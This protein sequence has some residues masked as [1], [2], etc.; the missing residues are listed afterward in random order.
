[1][2]KFGVS[3]FWALVFGTLLGGASYFRLERTDLIGEP[4]WHATVRLWLE[5]LEWAT[6]DWRARELGAASTPS[7][8]VVI[9]TVDE[10]TQAD[11]RE[12]EKP[13]WAMRPWPRDLSGAVIEQALKE[14]A[15]TVVFDQA[16]DDV[17]PHHCA[18]CRAEPK[19]SDDELFGDR[20]DKHAG[21]VVLTWD[22]SSNRPTQGNRPLMPVLVKLG[23]FDDVR[24]ALPMVREVLKHR[25]VTY[26]IADGGRQ[27]VWAGVASEAKARDLVQSVDPRVPVTTRPLL[28]G[29]DLH[30][31]SPSWLAVQLATVSVPGL[32]ADRLWRAR[33]VE[34]PVASLETPYSGAATLVPDADGRIRSVPL[35]VAADGADGRPVI[36]ASAVIRAVLQRLDDKSL[37]YEKGRLEIGKRISLPMDA[38]GT[39]QLRFDVE[40]VSR[41]G[42]STVKRSLPAF[43]LLVNRE[44]DEVARGIRHH[45]NELTGR[46]IVFSDERLAS[47]VVPTPVGDLH[48]SAVLAQ[49]IVNVLHAQSVVRVAPETDLWMTLAFAFMGAVLSVAWSSL[50][51]RPG[52]LAWVATLAGVALLHGL[53]ARQLFVQ[54]LRW[55]AMAAP[56]L[57]CAMTFLA[58]L[59]YARTIEQGLRDFVLR[60]LGGAVRDDVFSRVE[61]DLALMRPE[62]RELT[63]YFSDIEGF[64]VVAHEKDPGEVVQVLRAYLEEM[65]TVV[66]DSQG[67]VDKYLGDGL[68]AFWGAPVSLDNQVASACAAALEMQKRFEAKRE[69]WEKALG[70]T[71]ML[72]AGFDTGPTVVGEMG[73]LHRVNYTVMGE[74]VAASYRLEALAKKYNARVLV[75]PRVPELAGSKYFFREV[76]SI[77]LNRASEVVRIYELLGTEGDPAELMEWSLAM[78]AYR[79]RRFIEAR[80]IFQ[81]L[82]HSVPLATRY[83]R[84]CEALLQSPPPDPWDGTF[85]D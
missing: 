67:H 84:R 7:D 63:V 31:V 66:L 12:R 10:E 32:D 27:G 85:N 64:T 46:V 3:F 78:T 24:A 75:G 76:D 44:D 2:Q 69:A 52:W 71:L 13:E 6:W 70:R 14:G 55:V 28:P 49:A 16:L 38:D 62:R 29:D 21:N 82:E 58:S 83:A 35:F 57:A 34:A 45:D 73:T 80:A 40:D 19:K 1:M 68:M 18:P 48:R 61:R 60:A 65:T 74:P 5:R 72:R 20:L 43:R 77:R 54:Q 8:E 51:R 23:D 39:L 22:W 50:V 33:S 81:K 53:V 11:A 30:E 47:D 37:R 59:G 17:S 79:E 42:R 41:A 56:L 25:T 15:T 9:V 4:T 36:V 26:L